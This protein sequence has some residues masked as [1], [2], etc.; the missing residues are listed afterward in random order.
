[1]NE[2]FDVIVIGA[3][4]GG[5]VGAIRAAKLGL[6]TAIVE[7][8]DFGGTCLN[9]GCIPA[10][11]MIHAAS[12][13]R[14]FQEAERFGIHAEG[15]SCHF[16]ELLQYK[17]DTVSQLV[18]GVEQLLSANG[19]TVFR[20][21]G[22]LCP[23]K[24]VQVLGADGALLSEIGAEHVMLATG[25]KPILLPLPGM[26]LPRVLTSDGLFQ[27]RKLPE[28]LVIIGG[29]VIGVEFAAAW[30]ALG[31]KVTILEALPRLLPNM[32]KELSQNLKLILKK[33]GVDIHTAAGVK[34]VRMDGDDCVCT[35]QEKDEMQEAR[36]E[37]V[38]CAVGRCPN[39][40][41]LFDA[42]AVPAMERGRVLV[43]E[44]FESSI[45]GVYAIG[46][47]IFGTQLAHAASAQATA[48]AEALAGKAPSVNVSVIP[49][50]VYTEPEIGTVGITEDQAKEQGISA[51]TAK[52]VMSGNGKSI[53]TRSERGFIKVVAEEGTDRI[54]GVQMMCERATDM[55]GEFVT[56]IANGMNVHQLLSGMRAHPTYNEGVGE[57]LEELC[58]GAVHV[59]PKKKR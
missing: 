15:V 34:G 55:V 56:A 3:G 9:R 59:M 49:G 25:S 39:T 10:K 17:E 48:V 57:A 58:G 30:S 4:P 6:K 54:L 22:R 37:Y 2:K 33:R 12:L 26:E 44:R 16:E 45:P 19:V 20:G 31:T 53:I 38:L 28:S 32:D 46:D 24:R 43:N 40:D 11:A 36:A 14:E 18:Q 52:Y 35:Y 29:G 41:G 51:R 47:L 8:R 1:M 5:Y 23:E 42:D 13:Y 21:K 27:L 7:E 50:C